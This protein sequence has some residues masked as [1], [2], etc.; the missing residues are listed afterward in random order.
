MKKI[1][2]V[3]AL[4]VVLA[5]AAQSQP[6]YSAFLPDSQ[7]TP[8]ATFNVTANDVCTAGYAGRVRNV[9]QSEKNAVYAEY[10]IDHRQPGE[11]EVDH[12]ISLELGGSNDIKNLWPQSY[13]TKPLN[14]H[15]KD[16]L[17][18][19]LHREV[20]SGKVDLATAQHD[21]ATNWITSYQKYVGDLPTN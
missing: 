16:K 2:A 11:Y 21:I 6:D 8:G 17:E 5:L 14:A 7:L 19:A 4:I 12:L 10:H 9:P 13:V 1:P 20:C 18:N 3:F 15:V